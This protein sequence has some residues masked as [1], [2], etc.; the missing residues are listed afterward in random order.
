M[1][2]SFKGHPDS[3]ARRIEVQQLEESEARLRELTEHPEADDGPDW[4]DLTLDSTDEE[5]EAAALATFGPAQRDE[6]APTAPLRPPGAVDS[7]PLDRSW[8]RW[9][10]ERR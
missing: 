8:R 5:I 1:S 2:S 9:V 7:C 4:L 6:D 10:A 3:V